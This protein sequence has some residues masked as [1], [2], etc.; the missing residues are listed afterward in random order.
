MV[1]G[2]VLFATIVSGFLLY[3]AD[4]SQ[5]DSDFVLVGEIA[6]LGGALAGRWFPRSAFFIGRFNFANEK[7]RLDAYR[8]ALI[9]GLALA[10]AG[11]LALL[12]CMLLSQIVFPPLL[13]LSLPLW[14]MI[15]MRPSLRA[16]E[17][18]SRHHL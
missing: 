13:F 14:S 10:E 9:V 11:A 15:S 18:F 12:V 16:Y 5:G 7:N 2:I 3:L 6:A 1:V 4:R 17:A 8:L